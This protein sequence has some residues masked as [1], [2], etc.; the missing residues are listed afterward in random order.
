MS[1]ATILRDTVGASEIVTQHASEGDRWMSAVRGGAWDGY[2]SVMDLAGD[3]ATLHARVLA[4][5]KAAPNG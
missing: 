2:V 4:D 1:D 5:V 3:P